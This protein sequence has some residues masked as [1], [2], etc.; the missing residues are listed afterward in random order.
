[1][2]G[3]RSGEGV[4]VG[5]SLTLYKSNSKLSVVSENELLFI[6][7]GRVGVPSPTRLIFELPKTET[8]G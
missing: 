7:Y 6:L 2:V 4:N 1:M 8:V 5:I 3:Q